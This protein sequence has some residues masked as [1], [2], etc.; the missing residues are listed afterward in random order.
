[1]EGN[2]MAKKTGEMGTI[3]L[4]IYVL[5]CVLTLGGAWILKLIIQKAIIDA[6]V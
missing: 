3:G 6:K 2:I 1:V 5:V 4:N